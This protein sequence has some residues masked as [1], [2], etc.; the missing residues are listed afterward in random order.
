[1]KCLV[2]GG[3]GFIG[4]HLV[5]R[6]ILL[7]HEVHVID[8]LSANN[9]KFY[10]NE[11]AIYHKID[12][13]DLEQIEPLFKNI[14]YVFHLAAESRI[15]PSIENPLHAVNVNVIG[16]TN[17][18]QCSLKYKIK[19]VIYSGTSAVYGLTCSLPTNENEKI[20][21]LNPYSATKFAGEE[22]VRCYNKLHGL[23][24]CIFRYFNVYGERS[25]VSGPYSLVIGI[26]LSQ[27]DKQSLTVVG[28]GLNQRDFIHVYDVV[29]AN[30]S[31]MNTNKKLNAE[32]FN[33]GYGDNYKIID[34][35][36]M[37]SNNITYLPARL[38]EAKTTLA[39]I[40]K[41]K[42]IL[43]WNPSIKLKDWLNKIIN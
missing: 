18:L 42:T 17:I 31:A 41:A 12:I 43:N 10:F 13:C 15:Q 4:S 40:T 32:I 26:F 39:D 33:I 20:D 35:A 23:D 6:L 30:I 38:G 7:G 19:R 29:E 21:C 28:D 36:K 37:I 16:T 24:A 27:K 1:M 5:D 3:A 11:K 14:D 34:V 2:T 22:M 9:D 25:S 8:N